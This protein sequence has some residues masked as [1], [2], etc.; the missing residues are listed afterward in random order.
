MSSASDELGLTFQRG[1]QRARVCRALLA[2]VGAAECWTPTGPALAARAAPSRSSEPDTQ[3]I[4]A[5]CW[6]LWEGCSTLSLNELLLLDPSHLEATGELIA[7][8]ARGPAAVDDWLAR[9]E[10]AQGFSARAGGSSKTSAKVSTAN[11][12]KRVESALE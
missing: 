1:A 11:P 7:A 6:A 5:A 3:R 10:P 9:F 2:R 8:L 4:L 12:L